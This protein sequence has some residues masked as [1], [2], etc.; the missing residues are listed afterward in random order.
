MDDFYAAAYVYF[1]NVYGRG[2]IRNTTVLSVI[3]GIIRDNMKEFNYDSKTIF[4]F[5]DHAGK[6]FEKE[7]HNMHVKKQN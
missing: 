3:Y 6:I 5:R 1:L 2:L 7:I 4:K